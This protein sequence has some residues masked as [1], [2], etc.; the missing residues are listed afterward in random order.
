[1]KE[2]IDTRIEAD[3]SFMEVDNSKLI[4][5]KR[6]RNIKYSTHEEKKRISR[7]IDAAFLGLTI[8]GFTYLGYLAYAQK[9]INK[10]SK[11][12]TYFSDKA[13]TNAHLNAK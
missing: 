7:Y 12:N 6:A 5:N 13:S 4:G 11:P 2:T 3:H 8:M 1:M 10:L 9:E